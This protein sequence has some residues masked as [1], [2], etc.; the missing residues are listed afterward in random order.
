MTNNYSG[1]C[2]IRNY[3]FKKP[4]WFLKLQTGAKKARHTL[5]WK[6]QN[7]LRCG[8]TRNEETELDFGLNSV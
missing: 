4:A 6:A 3:K 7:C 1:S 8:E 2:D 5:P